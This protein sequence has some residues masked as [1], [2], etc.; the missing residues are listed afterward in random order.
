MGPRFV[1]RA[2][3]ANGPPTREF[4]WS[5]NR[6]GPEQSVTINALVDPRSALISVNIDARTC[7]TTLL[8]K[9]QKLV[10]IVEGRNGPGR[11]R[12]IKR[13]GKYIERWVAYL[14]VGGIVLFSRL[15]GSAARID[16]AC[17][18]QRYG[19]TRAGPAASS[20]PR[21]HFKLGGRPTLT[22]DWTARRPALG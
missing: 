3:G 8:V 1:A 19:S 22:R 11:E 10:I 17:V 4:A 13:D 12:L 15:R 5:S 21:T 9:L 20:F 18:G 14:P 16:G 6:L 2:P 7:S